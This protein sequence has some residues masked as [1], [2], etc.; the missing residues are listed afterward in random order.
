M[1]RLYDT[2]GFARSNLKMFAEAIED[3]SRALEL[4]DN[5]PRVYYHRAESAAQLG[6]VEDAYNDVSNALSLD[7]DFVPALRLKDRLDGGRFGLVR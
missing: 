5:N 7:P 3:F 4:N 6:E 2:R 1:H